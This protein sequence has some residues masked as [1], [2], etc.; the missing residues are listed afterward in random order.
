MSLLDPTHAGT[1]VGTKQ[2]NVADAG[3]VY[4]YVHVYEQPYVVRNIHVYT[5]GNTCV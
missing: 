3:Y 2:Y 1:Y 4:T 5:H